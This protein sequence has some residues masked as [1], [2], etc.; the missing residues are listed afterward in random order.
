MDYEFDIV[1]DLDLGTMPNPRKI[2]QAS[3]TG[4][5]FRSRMKNWQASP[6]MARPGQQPTPAIAAVEP[7]RV[8]MFNGSGT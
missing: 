2:V 4:G 7:V 8:P 6:R 5:W 1:F 3:L